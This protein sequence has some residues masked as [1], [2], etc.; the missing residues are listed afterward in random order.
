[1]ARKWTNIQKSGKEIKEMREQGKS[2]REISEE[3][4]LTIKQI[5]N[6][7]TKENHKKRAI[8]AGKTPKAK[9]RPRKESGSLEEEVRRLRMEN[10]LLRDFLLQ[11]GRR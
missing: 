7:I 6:H 4:G 9:G 3:L 11:A 8:E 2:R 10:E 1:M 5:E